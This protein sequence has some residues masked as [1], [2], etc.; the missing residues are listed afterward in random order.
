[1]E[2]KHYPVRVFWVL[3]AG[4]LVAQASAAPNDA[5]DRLVAAYPEYLVPSEQPNVVRWKDGTETPFDDGIVKT[6]FE[7]LLNRASL[8]DQMSMPYPAGWPVE[9]PGVNADPGR[10]RHEPFFAKMYGGSKVEVESRLVEVDWPAAG[11]GTTVKITRVNGVAE[12]LGRVARELAELPAETR[13][14]VSEPVGTFNWRP[15][16]G[17]SRQSMHGYGAAID[18][19]LPGSMYRYWRWEKDPGNPAYPAGILSDDR[20]GQIVRVFEK[21]GF[22]WGGKWYHFDTMHFEYRPELLSKAKQSAVGRRQAAVGS[23]QSAVGS[24]QSAVG[25][26]Q[27]AVGSR[28][29]AGGSRQSAVGKRQS[30]VGKRQSAVGKRQSAVGKRQSASG[31]RH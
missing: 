7:D 12:A 27:S 3:A 29:S 2:R 22:I 13:R 4:L 5:L 25:R 20:L 21:H 18:F 10:A 16:A 26:R 1:M 6:D 23:R 28:Q 8:K 14:Y 24:R 30:A 19:R 31:R 15:I 17:T 9:A 11:K